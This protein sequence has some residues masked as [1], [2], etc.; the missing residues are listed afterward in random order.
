MARNIERYRVSGNLKTTAS[1]KLLYMLLSEL[2]D[3]NGKVEISHKRLSRI[4]GIH[5]AT[6]S[7]NLRRLEENGNIFIYNRFDKDG[8]RIANLYVVR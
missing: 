5:K 8:G 6:V 1:G 4:L 3:E 7:K 2:A